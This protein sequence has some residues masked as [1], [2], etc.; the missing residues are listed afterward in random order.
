M[1]TLLDNGAS[2]AGHSIKHSGLAVRSAKAALLCL[3]PFHRSHWAYQRELSDPLT[4]SATS[5]PSSPSQAPASSHF[6]IGH[7]LPLHWLPRTII[8]SWQSRSNA[9]PCC[10]LSFLSTFLPHKRSRQSCCHLFFDAKI[11]KCRG[12]QP[13][14]R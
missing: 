12:L 2:P 9:K 3:F 5:H 7:P 1:E 8:G 13:P 11:M 14:R 10:W 6:N 4:G